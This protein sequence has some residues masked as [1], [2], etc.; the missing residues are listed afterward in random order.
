MIPLTLRTK[1]ERFIEDFVKNIPND[2]ELHLLIDLFKM[3][4]YPHE[5]TSKPSGKVIHFGWFILDNEEERNQF[6]ENYHEY[7]SYYEPTK[8]NIKLSPNEIAVKIEI[9]GF[10]KVTKKMI[11]RWGNPVKTKIRLD[12]RDNK[13]FRRYQL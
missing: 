10:N 4:E 6:F 3:E 9:A 13:Q 12:K 1:C 2:K 7:K 5:I 11:T 8:R